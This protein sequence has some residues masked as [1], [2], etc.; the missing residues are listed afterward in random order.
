MVTSRPTC[1]PRNVYVDLGVN[2]CNTL[3]LFRFAPVAR[4]RRGPWLI[5]G[6]EAAPPLL[7]FVQRCVDALSAGRPLPL[8]VVPST[9]STAEL[10]YWV[11]R[12]ANYSH[13]RDLGAMKRC[14]F[15]DPA[16]Q[17]KLQAL[18][19]D[20]T[21]SSNHLVRQ[22]LA[23]AARCPTRRDEYFLVPA[24]AGAAEGVVKLVGGMEQMLIGGLQPEERQ[25]LAYQLHDRPHNDPPPQQTWTVPKVDVISWL[26]EN[27]REQ[28]FV[29]LKVDIEGEE[30]AL[31][32][33]L[34]AANSSGLVDVLLW[35]CH[36]LPGSKCH[37][38]RRRLSAAG[39]INYHEPPW[40]KRQQRSSWEC[41]K[42]F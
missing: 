10:S 16:M 27:F 4:D 26:R 31:L 7:P 30:H 2:W 29:A 15:S 35:E 9:G 21:L 11:K 41:H 40:C 5:I 34:L 33:A 38:L 22:R 19:P 28:D 14:V 13:C 18:K 25:H 12:N 36:V 1:S 32:S 23:M 17:R 8:A 39:L 3:D 42:L 20:P 24:A 6:F 37:T